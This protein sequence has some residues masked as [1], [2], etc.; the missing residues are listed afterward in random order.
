MVISKKV[1]DHGGSELPLHQSQRAGQL[2]E[3]PAIFIVA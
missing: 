1:S 3:F 2:F